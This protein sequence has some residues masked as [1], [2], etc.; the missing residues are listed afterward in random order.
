[1]CEVC[2]MVW[3]VPGCPGYDEATAPGVIT[4]CERCGGPVRR[5]GCTICA[6][7]EEEDEQY[8]A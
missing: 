2:R 1:M 7:C 3:C 8:G 5:P 4:V 6:R